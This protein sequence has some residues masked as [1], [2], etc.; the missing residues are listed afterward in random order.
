MHFND[1]GFEGSVVVGWELHEKQLKSDL[2]PDQK[3]LHGVDL[4]L[5]RDSMDG[6]KMIKF[7]KKQFKARMICIEIVLIVKMDFKVVMKV[8]EGIESNDHS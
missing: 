3:Q 4:V 6:H 5:V 1:S 7:L 2:P 8:G